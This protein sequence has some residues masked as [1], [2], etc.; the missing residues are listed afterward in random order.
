MGVGEGQL[1]EAGNGEGG[2]AREGKSRIIY[3]FD[4]LDPF[5][6]P[7][8]TLSELRPQAHSPLQP[9]LLWDLGTLGVVLMGPLSSS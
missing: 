9:T 5:P 4:T 3:R 1:E 8:C 2:E 7:S 6:H